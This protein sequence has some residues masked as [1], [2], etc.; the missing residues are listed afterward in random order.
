MAA[1]L[2]GAPGRSTR[3]GV[4]DDFFDLGGH[5][6]LATQ[7]VSRL[8][9]ALRRRAA[10]A[11]CS[12]RRRVA[13]PGASAL[14]AAG[15]A[16]GGS[17][18]RSSPLPRDGPLPLS[19]A[20]Q[21]LWFLDQLEPGS[22]GLQHAGRA[23]ARRAALDPA[24]LAARPGRDRAPPRGAAHHASRPARRRAGAGDP[25]RRPPVAA[26]GG[27]PAGLPRGARAERGPPAGAEE[28][29]RPFDLARGPLLRAALL[30][31]G[32]ERARASCSTLH[33]IVSDGWSMGVLVRE[34]AALYGAVAPGARRRCR[35]CRSSTPTS[36]SGSASWLAGEALEAAARLLARA[37][38]RGAPA[39][40]SCRP[41]GRGRR[42]RA[43]AAPS[44]P[45]RACRRSSPRRSERLA[46]RAGRDP[47]HG[48]ARGASRRLLGRATGP[49][50]PAGRH[51][52]RRPRPAG[53]RGAD[54]LLR[55]HPGAARR[56]RRRSDASRELLA[57]V[58][59]TALGAYAHQELPF[60]Q[61]VEELR[62]ER[63]LR[64][65]RSSR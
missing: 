1:D 33:H 45:R 39:S 35:S 23:P 63:D 31:L 48:P 2:G 30:R 37:A 58:R 5:S 24:A 60:E 64:A 21:R 14:E 53:D 7:V 52:G 13:A 19:F 62:P 56:P 6:L 8:R 40:S 50:R 12:R 10:A 42:C 47:V 22:R 15:R 38:R 11:R 9:A 41:T 59:E 49:G 16:P 61:L 46:R 36:R 43:S 44:L 20:Q 25:S 55:Q 32:A 54:R 29:A 51:A 34:L 65:R 27:R 57:R 3:V 28:A 18:R 26:A 17:R 4:D